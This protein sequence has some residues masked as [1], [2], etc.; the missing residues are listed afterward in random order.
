MSARPSYAKRM[1]GW[2]DPPQLLRT[3]AL[4]LV[5]QQFAIH[6]DNR[7]IQALATP[8]HTPFDYA[9]N[10]PQGEDLWIDYVADCGDGW[11]STYAVASEL[12][13]DQL[14]VTLAEGRMCQSA[15]VEF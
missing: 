12:A 2:Y 7:E 10:L 11:N 14:L 1:V 13:K 5:S 3:G 4:V 15:E 6:A 8:D 9:A